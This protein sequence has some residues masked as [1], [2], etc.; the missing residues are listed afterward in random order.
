MI[1]EKNEML[2]M[3]VKICRG[4]LHG[5]WKKITTN[6]VVMKR[7]S[8]GLSNW[9]YHVK[10]VSENAEPSQV[11]LRIYGQTHGERAFESIITESVIFT[12]LSERKLGPKLHGIFPGGRLE[13]Y[14]PA[15]P[16]KTKELQDKK[17]SLLIADKMALVHQM[18]IPI[19]KEPR[20][21]W[22]T[23]NRWI[24]SIDDL[25][26]Y[27]YVGNQM[28]RKLMAQDFRIE[29][30]WL[31][32]HLQKLQSPVVFC[33][34]DFQEGNILMREENN[35]NESE[36][37]L[38]IIDFEYCAY[39]YRG[40]DL[41]NHFIEWTYDYSYPQPPYFSVHRDYYASHEQQLAFA[42]R[43]LNSLGNS[44]TDPE[45][46][47][48]EIRHFSLASHLFWGAWSL[49]QA[50]TSKI[51]FGYLEY[52]YERLNCYFNLKSELLLEA[53]AKKKLRINND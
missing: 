21:L 35:N 15:R 48:N 29:A 53:N 5:P 36:P 47:V 20:W 37:S 32:S 39:N 23:M 16:L 45:V 22:D 46:V 43:Y 9:L 51:K 7:V 49:V 38:V 50:K 14:I 12:L 10:L 8:G 17:L 24:Q 28:K 33:H 40:F 18:N 41:A 27:I 13:E 34:N 30:E 4:Y 26:L 2:Q 19:S 31:K 3:A 44:K 6:D 42:E 11:L 25:N 1:I 52:A